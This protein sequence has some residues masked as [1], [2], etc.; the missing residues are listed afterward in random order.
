MNKADSDYISSLLMGADLW[1]ATTAEEASI[2]VVNGC[3]VR[4]NAEAKAV[5]KVRYLERL[6][7]RRPELKIILTGCIVD[8]DILQLGAEFPHVDLFLKPQDWEGLRQWMSSEGLDVKETFPEASVSSLLPIISGCD[9]F[10]SY[11]IVPYRRGREKSVPP[12]EVLAKAELLVDKG[13]KEIVLLGQ[14]V[15]SYGRGLNPPTDLAY[16]LERLS[17]IDGPLR[18]R[19]LT[20][21]PK[22][23]SP[24]LIKA[25]A[26][27]PKVCEQLSLPFQSG[28]DEILKLMRREYTS[29]QYLD[30]VESIR[31][32]IPDVSISTDVIVGFP[33]EGGAHF[34]HTLDLI[35]KI[36]FDT[37]HVASYSPRE[38]TWSARNLPD[39]VENKEGR[40]RE[41][42]EVQKKIQGEINLSLLGERMEILVEGKKKG[43]WWGRTRG[44]KLVFF[45][46]DRNEEGKL[47]EV[48]INRASPWSL[49]GELC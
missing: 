25:M 13:A 49:Q 48:K 34:S 47:V 37:V 24:R 2:V 42:E 8:G 10:C 45:F 6:K 22:D 14:N 26:S 23:V 40:R 16:L 36:R 30:L 27:L 20:N 39:D 46:S 15:N 5:T 17:E 4:Q 18:I 33:G 28:D 38:G 7:L 44:G 32:A 11:C 21:H 19:F 1:K 31:S 43:K 41:V 35:K 29:R 12:E 9:N 3:V